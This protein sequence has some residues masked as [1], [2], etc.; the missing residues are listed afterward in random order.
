MKRAMRFISALVLAS[1][2]LGFGTVRAAHDPGLEDYAVGK[3]PAFQTSDRCLACHNGLTTAS[4]KDVSIGFDWRTSL[5]ANS[6]RDP[7]WQAGVRRETIDHPTAKAAIHPRQIAAISTVMRPSEAEITEAQEA[8]DAF[9]AGGGRAI[10][11]RGRMLEA[12]VMHRYRRI[13]A[14]AGIPASQIDQTT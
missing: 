11:F 2:V 5:M 12:P 13:L 1:A 4:G 10:A 8:L 14:L 9:A 7:Y 3:Q 6:G